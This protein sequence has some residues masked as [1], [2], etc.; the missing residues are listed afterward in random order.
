Y[1]DEQTESCA[2]CVCNP[3]ELGSCLNENQIEVC[4]DACGGYDPQDCVG[5]VC[6]VDA[7]VDLIC[8]PNEPTCE[9]NNTYKLCNDKGTDFLPPVD[10]QPGDVCVNGTCVSACEA[11]ASQKSN[12][13]CEF[14]AVDM[15][16]LPPRDK[17][18]YAVALSNPSFTDTVNVE[19][20]DRNNNNN[21]QKIITGTIAARQ[22]KVF[23]LSGS[24]NGYTSFYNGQDAGFLD[25]GIALGRA[26][27]V[28][29]DLPVLATQFN[30]IGGA[31]GYTTDASLLLP[32]HT[33]GKAYYHMAWTNGY[34]NGSAMNIVATED[35]TTVTITPKVNTQAGKNGLPAMAA[36][37]PT[38]IK[39]GRY[40]YIQVMSGTNGPDL[41]GS[42][43]EASAPVAVFGGHSCA[44][45][46]TTSIAACDHI[47]EQILPLETW[48]KNYIAV[49]NPPRPENNPEDMVW[50][51]IAAEDN[52]TVTFDPPVTIGAMT[53]LSAGQMVQFVDKKSFSVSAN[54]P[55]LVVGYM[56]GCTGTSIYPQQCDGD[57]YMVQ[58]VAVEQ[59]LKDYVFLIDSSYTKDFA[60]LIRPAGKAV[61]VGCLGV[62]PEN[63]WTAVGKS[64]YDVATIDMNPGEANCKPGTNEASSDAGFGIVVSGRAYAA[65]YA[66]PGGLALQVINPQ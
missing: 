56:I 66:Y 59:Y 20:Y 36:N 64:G 19:I 46:P 23:N 14:W 53:N 38:Q 8:V 5:Q 25:D 48:G 35:N 41:S 31:S 18:T 10:C 50:R 9:D 45:V 4:N 21:E 27:R 3:G 40:D 1:C 37:V 51:I 47:E 16:N 2:P 34:G 15:D 57:P 28:K 33:L 30:P 42:K 11:A 62:V 26:F 29:T 60:Q 22:V 55:I 6:V 63:R 49:R 54:D 13:G 32:T 43:I 52:T 39:I 7:C 58:M 12:I 65:S 61:D 44:N 17:Y 24:H